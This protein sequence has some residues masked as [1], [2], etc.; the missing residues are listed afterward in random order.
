MLVGPKRE[1]DPLALAASAPWGHMGL[2]HMGLSQINLGRMGYNDSG[3]NGSSYNGS[4]L[5][6]R[7]QRRR[8]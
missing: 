3:Y 5:G 4:V 2:S 6:L 8:R 1:R 7:R